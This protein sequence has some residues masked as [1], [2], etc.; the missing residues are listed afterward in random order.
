MGFDKA[1]LLL[2]QANCCREC[3]RRSSDQHRSEGRSYAV[4]RFVCFV[5]FVV[6]T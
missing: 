3:T 2:A 6:Q 4:F 1:G 5:C